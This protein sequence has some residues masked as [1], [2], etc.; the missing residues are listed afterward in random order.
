MS[1][2]SRLK[3]AMN[4]CLPVM[5]NTPRAPTQLVHQWQLHRMPPVGKGQSIQPVRCSHA[6]SFGMHNLH[7]VP[8]G[9]RV[10]GAEGKE[11]CVRIKGARRNC[12][13]AHG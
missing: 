9:W 5:H 7:K 8:C 1:S 2:H 4:S 6:R 13:G 10:R 11:L 12:M 3:Q